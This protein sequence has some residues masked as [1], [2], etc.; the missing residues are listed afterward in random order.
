MPDGARAPKTPKRMGSEDYLL[1]LAS[2]TASLICILGRH[3]KHTFVMLM[4]SIDS[5][6]TW[7]ILKS[8]ICPTG[9]N[10]ITRYLLL[11]IQNHYYLFV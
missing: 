3:L 4:P 8:W 9:F 7:L 1:P 2:L 6:Y 11:N 5:S 10:F